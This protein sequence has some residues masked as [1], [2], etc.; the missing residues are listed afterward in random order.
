MA[1]GIVKWFDEERGFGFIVPADGGKY[2]F[3]HYS[4]I[5]TG[6]PTSLSRGQTVEF[7]VKHG[8]KGLHATAIRPAPSS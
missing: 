2:L 3:A 8:A 1:L 4:E 5:E 7:V 6:G